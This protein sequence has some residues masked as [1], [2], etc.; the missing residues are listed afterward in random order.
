M[1]LFAPEAEGHGTD[2]VIRAYHNADGRIRPPVPLIKLI[3]SAITIGSGGSAG[4]EGPAALIASG[5][6]SIYASVFKRSPEARRVLV[7][8]GMA[9]GLSAIFRA[10][11]GTAHSPRAY[12]G[13]SGRTVRLVCGPR[14]GTLREHSTC[15]GR[16]IRSRCLGGADGDAQIVL[17]FRAG[18]LLGP[19]EENPFQPGDQV[20]VIASEPGWVKMTDHLDSPPP[21]AA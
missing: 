9:A 21:E 18:H 6:A 17:V 20:L 12:P 7:L 4:L 16:P 13:P 10:P 19:D 11:I 2:T 15:V 8:C 3:A 5:L 1:N 14:R